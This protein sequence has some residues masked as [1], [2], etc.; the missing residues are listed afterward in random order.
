MR[1]INQQVMRHFHFTLESSAHKVTIYTT[2]SHL[3]KF[4]DDPVFPVIFLYS[5]QFFTFYIRFVYN[6]YHHS[7]GRYFFSYSAGDLF[8]DYFERCL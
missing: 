8:S 4:A 5:N 7:Y 6:L 3:L 1:Y 2:V